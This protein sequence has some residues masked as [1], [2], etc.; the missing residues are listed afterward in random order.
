[1]FFIIIKPIKT[2]GRNVYT[3]IYVYNSKKG[4]NN[5]IYQFVSNIVKIILIL[6]VEECS[7]TIGYVSITCTVELRTW[8]GENML[9]GFVL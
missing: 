2:D 1:M 6:L 9:L 3:D 8:D 4:K 7:S 5:K